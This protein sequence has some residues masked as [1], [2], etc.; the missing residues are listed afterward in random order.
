MAGK[1]VVNVIMEGIVKQI[2][3]IPSIKCICGAN[4]WKIFNKMKNCT[5]LVPF[6]KHGYQ[7]G[8]TWKIRVKKVPKMK[9]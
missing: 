2:P 4:V 8:T 1:E 9:L 6:I 7:W 5:E 3:Q